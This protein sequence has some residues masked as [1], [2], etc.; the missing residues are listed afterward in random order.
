MKFDL[1]QQLD[2]KRAD[3]YYSKLKRLGKQ[4]ELKEVKL[5]RSQQQNKAL[6]V[7][8]TLISYE[9]NDLGH[10]F[11]YNGIKGDT[12]SMRYTP[13]IVKEFIWRPIQLALFK[14]KSTT[15]INTIEINEIVDVIT[16]FFAE[17]GVVI[18]FPSIESL[19]SKKKGS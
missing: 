16:K 1:Q 7:Y 5:T 13:D 8:F 3:E 17:K 14:I 12:F 2:E 10:E 4:I 15:K 9:L 11:L 6:H 19:M 18:E